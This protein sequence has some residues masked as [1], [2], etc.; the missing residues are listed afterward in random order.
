MH[1]NKKKKTEAEIRA[2]REEKKKSFN[3][4]GSTNIEQIQYL[5]YLSVSSHSAATLAQGDLN[6][7]GRQACP[8]V[9]HHVVCTKHMDFLVKCLHGMRGEAALPGEEGVRL[10]LITHLSLDCLRLSDLGQ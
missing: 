7:R 5:F 9:F 10:W 8:F 1:A 2:N 3:R 6:M 4:A